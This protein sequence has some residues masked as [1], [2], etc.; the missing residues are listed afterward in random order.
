MN[1]EVGRAGHCFFFFFFS[2]KRGR[3]PK[4][5]SPNNHV[6]GQNPNKGK[7]RGAIHPKL[8]QEMSY[9]DSPT[10]WGHCSYQR[11]LLH[12]YSI[13]YLDNHTV[14]WYLHRV[15]KLLVGGPML[16]SGTTLLVR[17]PN[18]PPSFMSAIMPTSNLEQ[19]C[20]ILVL[21][22]LIHPQITFSDPFKP[23]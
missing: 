19:T 1:R 3:H 12:Y 23:W 21:P 14:T 15:L 9:G 4:R 5:Q 7:T 22:I 6:K 10:K 13:S 20:G 16:C 2:E 17:V 11:H 8:D 18:I